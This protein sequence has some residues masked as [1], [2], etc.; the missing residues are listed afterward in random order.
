MYLKQK[1]IELIETIEVGAVGSTQRPLKGYG[2]RI[3]GKGTSSVTGERPAPRVGFSN[4]PLP[5]PGEPVAS[6][7]EPGQ[8]GV[9]ARRKKL[10]RKI[11]TLRDKDAY[12]GIVR[13]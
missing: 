3:S 2:M 8:A 6:T 13:P 5:G 4:K 1:L 12:T 11:R 7:A 10:A 9:P